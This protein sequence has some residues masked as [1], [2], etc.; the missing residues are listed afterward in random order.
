MLGK[1]RAAR[2][3]EALDRLLQERSNSQCA[4]CGED[5][6]SWASANIGVFLC[7][8]CASIHRKLGSHISKVKSLT[9]DDWSENEVEHM[10][11]WG[12]KRANRYWN[13]YPRDNP[14]PIT[15][16]DDLTVERYLRDKY[17]KRLF[18][19]DNGDYDERGSR[20]RNG[21]SRRKNY[22]EPVS[23]RTA[24]ASHTS[25]PAPQRSKY[26]VLTGGPS[27][28][29]DRFTYRRELSR[30]EDMGFEDMDMNIEALKAAGNNFNRAI[31]ILTNQSTT[32]NKED[33]P[34][35]SLPPRPID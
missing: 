7:G 21:D 14:P 6:V 18:R 4:E 17:E 19:G 25:S 12:N 35:P 8:R 29:K 27:N 10:K 5:G 32:P 30:L 3:R 26:P 13:P 15:D 24:S 34:P 23:R 2:N 1:R 31:D 22:Y 11:E 16:D 20:R 33:S 9:L 28:P